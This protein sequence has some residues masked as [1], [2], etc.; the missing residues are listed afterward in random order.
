MPKTA[1]QGPTA[2]PDTGYR[3]D[4]PHKRDAKLLRLFLKLVNQRKGMSHK[5]IATYLECD[6]GTVTRLIADLQQEGL[7]MVVTEKYGRQN[8]YRLET[9]GDNHPL[10][11]TLDAEGL[12]QLLLCRDFMRHLLPEEQRRSLDKALYQARTHTQRKGADAADFVDF[13]P[14]GQVYA[15]GRLDY[16]GH[17]G[18]LATLEQ[19]IVREKICVITHRPSLTGEAREHH[20]AP[21]R[22]V[23]MNEAIYVLGWIVEERGKPRCKHDAPTVFALHRITAALLLTKYGS[24]ELPR[25]PDA[26]EKDTAF[27][28]MHTGEPF[29]V[30][31]RFS[32]RVGTYVAERR[33]CDNEEKTV[34]KD[35]SVT[36]TLHANN[37]DE[38]VAWLL[39]FG[40]EAEVLSPASLRDALHRQA[41]DMLAV[42]AKKQG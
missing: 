14:V 1:T 18:V 12:R 16:S 5:E 21:L 40:R 27:G 34:H 9:V 24:T 38:V 17:A 6:S 32:P 15:K 13:T 2:T 29:A 3:R 20:F 7:A 42:Y 37:E 8:I 30:V 28:L 10:P 22:L 41:Q 4:V 39:G 31:V 19:A 23:R 36:V 26:V 33:W 25:L 35:G 11:L